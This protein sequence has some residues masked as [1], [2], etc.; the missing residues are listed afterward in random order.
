MH[1]EPCPRC[2]HVG[3]VVY[4]GNYWCTRCPWA[5]AEGG[6]PKRIIGAYLRQLKA[7]YLA[8]D[9]ARN[10]ALMESYL[11]DIGMATAR[12]QNPAEAAEKEKTATDPTNLPPRRHGISLD[13][14]SVRAELD[15][16]PAE[17]HD[18]TPQQAALIQ[19]LG[20]DEINRAITQAV[21]DDFWAQYDAVRRC[22]I[23]TLA[24]THAAG[25]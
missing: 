5:M 18:L 13:A 15:D 3:T 10:A 17:A 14:D 9:D 8:R 6:R 1:D 7:E 21:D 24:Q 4:D 16:A 12:D 25:A 20:D 11:Q 2:R 22:A 23:A 19:H